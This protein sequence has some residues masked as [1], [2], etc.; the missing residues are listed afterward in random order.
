MKYLAVILGAVSTATAHGA[1]YYKYVPESLRIRILAEQ[2]EVA[3]TDNISI[4]NV[5]L[6]NP[7]ATA[8]IKIP[9]PKKKELKLNHIYHQSVDSGFTDIGPMMGKTSIRF[10]TNSSEWAYG[11]YTGPYPSSISKYDGQKSDKLTLGPETPTQQVTVTCAVPQYLIGPRNMSWYYD[12]IG[13]NMST[14]DWPDALNN[15]YV[16]ATCMLSYK[17]VPEVAIQLMNDHMVIE[18]TAGTSEIY[19]NQLIASGYGGYGV[20]ARLSINNPNRPDVSV[21]FS[22]SDPDQ[23][24]ATVLPTDTGQPTDFYVKVNRTEPGSREYIVNFTAQYD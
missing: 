20:R 15:P 1:A 4:D 22:S 3:Y 9:W 13:V 10:A 7:R 21:S 18:G 2:R 16:T 14:T 23:T 11:E 19:K 8:T 12:T 6:D 17:V 24:T 5:S